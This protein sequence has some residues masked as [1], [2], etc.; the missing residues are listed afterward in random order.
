[1]KSEFLKYLSVALAS[2][3][4]FF[5]GPIT[6][7]VLKLNWVETAICS[8][9]GMMFTVF[10]LTYVGKGIQALTAKRRK[11]P[12]KRFTRTNRLA[13]RIWKKFGIV[14]IAF[15]TPPLFTPLFGPILAVAFKVPRASI[16]LWMAVSAVAWGLGISYIAH[17][18]TFIQ[19]WFR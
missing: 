2:T 9:A 10:L 14:G 13:V 4:K 12:P 8:A 6:G 11:T 1:M 3:L 5:G 19:E 17:K 18:V 15:L 16:F 7:V